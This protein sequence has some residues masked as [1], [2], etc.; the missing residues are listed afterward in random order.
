[1]SEHKNQS[2]FEWQPLRKQDF[3]IW[4]DFYELTEQKHDLKLLEHFFFF[5]D[6]HIEKSWPVNQSDLGVKEQSRGTIVF[7]NIGEMRWL[8]WD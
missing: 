3:V 2:I 6:C 4:L 7:K 1:M 8:N 5:S